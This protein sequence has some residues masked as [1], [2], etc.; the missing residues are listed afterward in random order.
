[1]SLLQ[2]RELREKRRRTW[3]EAQGL[4]TAAETDNRD[5]SDDEQQQF[6]RMDAEMIELEARAQRLLR[7]HDVEAELDENGVRQ[8]DQTAIENPEGNANQETEQKAA[9]GKAWQKWL[10]FGIGELDPEERKVLRTGY[11]ELSGEEKRAQS[12]GVTTAGGFTVP[13][14]A[15]QPLED[16]MLAF[17]GMRQSRTTII[18][19]GTGA[20]MPIPTDDDTSNAGVLLAENTAATEQDFVFGQVVL[21]AFKYTSKLVRVSIELLQDSNFNMSQFL[22]RKLGER[23]GRITNT[24]FTTGDAA[25]KPNGVVTA[26]VVGKVGATGQTLTIIYDDLVDLQHSVDPSYRPNAE[27]MLHDL[28]VAIIKKLKTTDGLPLWAPGIAVREPDRILDHTFVVNQDIAQMAANAKSVLFG[29]LSKYW[30]RDV[31][32]ILLLRLEE[33][34]AE[35]GQ[36]AFLAFSRHDGDLIDAGTNPV[37]HYA[38]SA[39]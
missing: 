6:D 28:S 13:D 22:G 21:Q 26:S 27:F 25:S 39:T 11:K 1:M 24:H 36:V 10:R 4:L 33:R 32:E 17:G 30:I 3:E 29:D 23:I 8:S 12:V 38:N 7:M 18:R 9:Y 5:L 34:Y 37:K 15:M 14:E 16:A 2:V 31:M 20:D 19:T 35:F